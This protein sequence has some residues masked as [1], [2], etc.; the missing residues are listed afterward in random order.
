MLA[1]NE[2]RAG[3]ESRRFHRAS[4]PLRATKN[5]FRSSLG[6]VGKYRRAY[7]LLNLAYYGLMVGAMVYAAFHPA[8]QRTLLDA[9]GEAV[10]TGPMQTV[11]GAYLGGHL[12]LAMV[13]TFAV[14]LV[15]GS[16]A[17][18]ALPSLIVPFSGLLLG[19][20]RAILWGL[21]FSP[22]AVMG[23]GFFLLLPTIVLEGQGYV[24]AMLAAYVQGV[25]FL[26]PESVGAKTHRRGYWEGLKRSARIYVLVA[27][28]L[29][30]AAVV[31]AASVIFVM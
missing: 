15:G 17:Y 21:M 24:L 19:A 14:N 5:M 10:G 2:H 7:L 4:K 23:A 22:T 20:F 13:L 30:V 28:V 3:G 16:F 11:A 8:L 6:V 27:I 18:I 1:N 29:L 25:A 31:E 9:M 12:L 26:R